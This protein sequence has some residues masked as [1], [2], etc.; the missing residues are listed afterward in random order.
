PRAGELV[1]GVHDFV[2]APPAHLDPRI[3]AQYDIAIV[4]HEGDKRAVYQVTFMGADK[5]PGRQQRIVF[6]QGA[7][8]DKGFAGDGEKPGVIAHRFAPDDVAGQQVMDAF[9][10]W[11]R[12]PEVS[13]RRS[14]Q[15][16]QHIGEQVVLLAVIGLLADKP[17]D[18]GLQFF[19]VDRFEQIVKRAVPDRLDGIFVVRGGKD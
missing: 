6:T 15:V 5:L 7:G 14:R 9:L 13:R 11:Q 18:G 17:A 2:F 19:Q 12:E 4:I 16:V 1:K 10:G 3:I 8:D